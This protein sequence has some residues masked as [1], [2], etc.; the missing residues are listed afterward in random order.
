MLCRIIKV[1]F[2]CEK[3]VESKTADE[4]VLSDSKQKEDM[5][6]LFQLTLEQLEPK[7]IEKRYN[8]DSVVN[9][10]YADS[11]IEQNFAC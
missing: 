5:W 3:L 10:N 8:N 1:S 2:W 9:T 6:Q 4:S 11:H 7:I